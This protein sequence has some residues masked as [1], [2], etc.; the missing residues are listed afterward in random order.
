MR[1]FFV[2]YTLLMYGERKFFVEPLAQEKFPGI[3]Q[4]EERSYCGE[5]VCTSIDILNIQ[6]LTKEDYESFISQE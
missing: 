1:Y 6:E 3:K 5:G 2:S 4:I